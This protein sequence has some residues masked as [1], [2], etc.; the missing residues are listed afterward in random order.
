MKNIPK[1][2]LAR[3]VSFFSRLNYTLILPIG[4][5]GF[6]N[7]F[8]LSDIQIP[9]HDTFQLF[10][11]FHFFYSDFYYNNEIAQWLPYQTYGLPAGFEMFIDFT[12]FKYFFALAGKILRVINVLLLFKISIIVEQIVFVSGVFILARR[13]YR[14]QSTILFV[15]LTAAASIVWHAAIGLNFLIYYLLPYVLYFLIRFFEEEKPQYFWLSGLMIVIW[16]M[17]STALYFVFLWSLLLLIIIGFLWMKKKIDLRIII[18]P[19]RENY[20]AL[21]IFLIAA[22][23]ISVFIYR[24]LQYIDIVSPS[25]EAGTMRSSLLNFLTYGDN[26]N[27]SALIN[28]I[29]IGQPFYLQVGTFDNT[30]YVGILPIFFFIWALFKV[31]RAEF[32]AF[33][34][35]AIFLVWISLGGIFASFIY[36]IPGM[37]FYR[38]IGIVYGLVKFFII[39]CAGFGFEKFFLDFKPRKIWVLVFGMLILVLFCYDM[40]VAPHLFQVEK[41]SSFWQ[42]INLLTKNV[43]SAITK[44]GIYL[45]LVGMAFIAWVI[46]NRIRSRKGS[47]S[48]KITCKKGMVWAILIGLTI[49]LLLYQYVV[50]IFSKKIKP[51]EYKNIESVAV[52]SLI[53]QPKRLENPVTPL[54]SKAMGLVQN[55]THHSQYSTDYNFVQFDPCFSRF[56]IDF[57]GKN[58][59]P[60]NLIKYDHLEIYK[61]VIACQEP[62][63]SLHQQVEPYRSHEEAISKITD[64]KYKGFLLIKRDSEKDQKVD[65]QLSRRGFIEVDSF[66]ANRIAMNILNS[67]QKPKW[68]YYAD[69]NHPGWQAVIDGKK[70][71]I[72]EA[73]LAFKGI[74]IPEQSQSIVFLFFDKINT[75]LSY[76]IVVF[77][78]LTA[79]IFFIVILRLLFNG[80]KQKEEM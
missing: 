17:G 20:I 55:S 1:I 30:A 50:L 3:L 57:Q 9:L 80:S 41:W 36:Y 62:K 65:G 71:R 73:F 23:I 26:P 72:H 40:T 27:L 31:K 13:L 11:M 45:V 37:S 12:I 54:Q 48:G 60:L 78:V 5:L 61:S 19:S 76:L 28:H 63:I 4:V 6:I 69:T 7:Y 79:V 25:R 53:Y 66:S 14:N 58:H 67:D 74:Y 38:H 33:M 75:P 15:C 56:R 2:W 21:A 77:S 49:D 16:L 68:L 39:F 34:A 52:R 44:I 46:Y 47:G 70:A 43:N 32:W 59:A 22:V 24:S 64:Q 42:A 10:G 8:Y 29:V 35:S 51:K 18:K